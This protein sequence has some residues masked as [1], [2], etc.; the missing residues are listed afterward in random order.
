MDRVTEILMTALK[1]ALLDPGGE[2]RLYRS[3]KLDGL[4]P[5]KAGASGDAAARAVR[6]SL[7]E[8]VRSETR[9]K[10]VLDWVRLTARGVDFVHE[11]ESPVH[12][13]HE[14]RDV[15]RANQQALPVWLESMRAGLAALD[16]RLALDAR[17]WTQRLDALALRVDTALK[18]LEDARQ[19][20]PPEL[21]SD[22]PWVVDAVNYL[23]RR[24][25]GGAPG[26]CPLPELFT[27]LARQHN[28]LSIGAF[29][30]GLRRLGE[31]RLVRLSSAASHAEL[32]QP[33]FA[34]LRDGEVLYYAGR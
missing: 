2:H 30:E 19:P 4:F 3:G 18:R 7:V 33:E 15:L 25:D 9:G 13:L 5:S 34:L 28:G 6:D 1:E 20:L 31:H 24:R 29:H 8:V 22:Q 10:T 32:A 26:D 11:Q 23:D 27:S 17:K 21:E 12:A 14:L 16:E